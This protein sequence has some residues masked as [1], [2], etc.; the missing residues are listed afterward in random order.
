MYS[1]IKIAKS[2]CLLFLPLFALSACGGGSTST[3]STSQ[4]PDTADKVD[5]IVTLNGS[6]TL[7]VIKGSTYVDAGATASD[8]VDGNITSNITIAGDTVDTKASLGS[9]FTITYNVKDSAGNSAVEGIRTVSIIAATT[10]P[11]IPT[12]SEVDKAIY[13]TLI[14]EAR[15]EARTCVDKQGNSTGN[16]PAVSAVAWNEKLYK[17]S[18]EHSQD[19]AK[20]NTFSHDGSGTIHDWSGYAKNKSSDMKDR[21][22]AYRYAWAWVSENISAGTYRDTPEEAIDSWLKSPGHCHNIMSADMT[23]VGMALV[24]DSSSKYKHYWTQNFGKP[25]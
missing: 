7:Q 9:T 3:P 14:N 1:H 5:P 8:N 23:E 24:K 20:S 2:V 4:K 16:F 25:R 21:V 15:A 12:L 19:L 22:E 11:R 10:K 18:Y 6:T 13:L 17:S